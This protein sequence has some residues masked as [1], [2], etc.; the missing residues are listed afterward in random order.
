MGPRRCEGIEIFFVVWSLA[1]LG[2]RLLM[3]TFAHLYK[4]CFAFSWYF[5]LSELVSFGLAGLL[6]IGVTEDWSIN[7]SC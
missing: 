1:L 4:G 7:C 3:I 2:C 5:F 6:T